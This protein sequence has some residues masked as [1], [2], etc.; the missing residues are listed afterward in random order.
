ME[1]RLKNE[2]E[3]AK[4]QLNRWTAFLQSYPVDLMV[5]IMKEMKINYEDIYKKAL[6]QEAFVEAY[7][8]AY[9]SVKG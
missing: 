4:D 7:F 5:G 6:E 8:S 9:R 2:E 3:L 1:V